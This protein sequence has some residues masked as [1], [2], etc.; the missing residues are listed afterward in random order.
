MGTSPSQIVADKSLS[1][2]MFDGIARGYDFANALISMGQHRRW[3]QG[4]RDHLP[5]RNRLEI[6]DLATGTGDV[7]LMLAQDSRVRSVMATDL[8]AGMLAVARQKI[9]A[10]QQQD[11]ITVATQDATNLTFPEGTYDAVTM[12]FGI[13][14][15]PSPDACL[16]EIYRV[17][18]P[19]GRILI[20]ES[21]RP[22]AGSLLGKG[23]K[24]YT[25]RLLPWIGG[26]AGGDIGAYR[27]LHKSVAVFPCGAA[28]A[29]QMTAAGFRD[30]GFQTYLA[31]SVF[32]YWGTK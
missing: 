32:L 26:L 17:L 25:E 11:R 16:A 14:N 20:L 4:I 1:P 10:H 28:F 5:L 18:K 7:A 2:T 9:A 13:R 31:G 23:H 19:E 29:D 30:V 21:G 27:Y 22:P 8:S 24:V 15:V 6:L 12:A 3:R